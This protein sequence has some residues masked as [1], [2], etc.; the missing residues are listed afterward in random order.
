MPAFRPIEGRGCGARDLRV[1][2]DAPAT[3]SAT[4]RTRIANGSALL[5]GADHR[6]FWARRLRELLEDFAADIPNASCAE[7]SIIRRASVLTIELERLESK[8]AQAGEATA[9]DLE[10]YQ[11][12]AGNM[13]RLLEA[14]GLQRRTRDVTPTLDEYLRARRAEQEP[15]A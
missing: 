14:V 3:L 15:A 11:R 12:T 5:A 13:R 1:M 4:Q 2:A 7:S 6:E 10:L 8:F 9:T